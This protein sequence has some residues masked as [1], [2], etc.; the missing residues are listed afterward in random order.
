MTKKGN[1]L[2]YRRRVVARIK[3]I[4]GG[5]PAFAL[6]KYDEM[7]IYDSYAKGHLVSVVASSI[8]EEKIKE[9]KKS[10]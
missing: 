9:A 7:G 4:I 8:V 6:D 2:T 1:F 10:S 3:K 5:K